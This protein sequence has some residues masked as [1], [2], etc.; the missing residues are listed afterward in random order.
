MEKY[1][2]NLDISIKIG[3]LNM[4]KMQC[5]ILDLLTFSL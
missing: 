2:G 4:K 5:F 1:C 3:L